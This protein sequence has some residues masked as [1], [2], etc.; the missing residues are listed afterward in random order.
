M[1]NEAS[2]GVEDLLSQ[3]TLGPA[4]IALRDGLHIST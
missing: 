3:V 2:E 4:R 1:L